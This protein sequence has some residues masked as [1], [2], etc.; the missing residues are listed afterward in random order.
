L[1]KLIEHY[2]LNVRATLGQQLPQ[3]PFQCLYRLYVS[4]D[5]KKIEALLHKVVGKSAACFVVAP[6]NHGVCFHVT[7]F[8]LELSGSGIRLSHLLVLEVLYLVSNWNKILWSVHEALYPN[9]KMIGQTFHL[10]KQV[11]STRDACRP[12]YRLRD[13]KVNAPIGETHT[14][15]RQGNAHSAHMVKGEELLFHDRD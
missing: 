3:L 1:I 2:F 14:Y 6:V 5:Q 11:K 10:A 4:L 13:E 8:T 12:K 7:C 9:E 15:S